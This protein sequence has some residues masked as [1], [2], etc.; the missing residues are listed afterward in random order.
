MKTH[1][2]TIQGQKVTAY[3]DSNAEWVVQLNDHTDRFDMRNWT[4]KDAM[5]FMVEIWGNK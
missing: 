1:T 5:S 3:N 4:M 2:K